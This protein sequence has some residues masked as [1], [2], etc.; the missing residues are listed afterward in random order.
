MNQPIHR[1]QADEDIFT[2]QVSDEALEA[3]ATGWINGT[4]GKTYCAGDC[5]TKKYVRT[6]KE[7]DCKR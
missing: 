7:Y 3:T 4:D 2:N 1:K 5:M 6:T